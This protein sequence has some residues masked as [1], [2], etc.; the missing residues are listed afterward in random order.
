MPR[1]ANLS[2]S[3]RV[4]M[5]VP[6]GVAHALEVLARRGLLGISPPDVA[7]YLLTQRIQEMVQEGSLSAED[8]QATS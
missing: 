6:P 2:A 5:R 8:A 1:K 7:R 4:E 3:E